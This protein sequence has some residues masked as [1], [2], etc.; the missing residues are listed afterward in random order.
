[1]PLVKDMNTYKISRAS[2]TVVAS[3]SPQGYFIW[4]NTI[5]FTFTM[6]TPMRTKHQ[7]IGE[8]SISQSFILPYNDCEKPL[9]LL[10]V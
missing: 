10:D 7:I 9:N 8:K 1:M 3:D 6:P 4:K 2:T 5:F